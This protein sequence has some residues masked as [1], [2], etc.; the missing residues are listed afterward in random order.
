MHDVAHI[1]LHPLP[2]LLVLWP[3]VCAVLVRPLGRWREDVRDGFML[4]AT[5]VTLLG[6]AA[7]I[8]LIAEEHRIAADIPALLGM[9]H[10]VV[11]PF[12]ML[13]A[14]FTTFVWFAATLHS[15]DYLAHEQ[16]RDRFHVTSLVVL[17]A[18]LGVVLA[19]NL[20]TLYLFFEVLGLT[21]FLFVIHTQT[22]EAK[23]ASIKYLW[24]TVLGGF[25]LVAGIFLTYA[26]GHTGAI[27]PIPLEGTNE[28]LRWVTFGLLILGFGVKAGML[29][30][31]VWLP[32][33]HPVAPSPASALLSGVMIKA[34]AY[35][36]FR[37][38]TALFRP[39]VLEDISE[40][41]WHATSSFGLVVLWIGI[42]TMAIGVILALGQHN[43]KRML[44]YHSVSQM[45]FILAGIGAAGYLG[46]HGALG[47]AGGLLHVVNH[48]LFKGA[49]FLGI[50]A[51][52]FR[53]GELDMY[54]LGGLWR[55]MPWT[56]V[57]MLIAAAGI[58]GVPLFNGFVSKC[59]IHHALVEAYEVHHLLSLNIAEKIYVVTCGGTA[60]SFIKLIGLV[61]LGRAKQEY[62]PEVTDAP[63]RMLMALALLSAAMVT[64]GV[65]PHLLLRGVVSPGL[66]EW[67]LHADLIEY[68]LT[69]YF[70]SPADLMSVVVAFAIGATIFVVGMKLGLFHR[71]APAWFG[72]DYWYRRFASGFVTACRFI[73]EWY[74]RWIHALSHLLRSMRLGYRSLY[75]RTERN[76]HRTVV[77]ITTGAPG[78]RNQHFIQNAYIALERER[79]ASVRLAV[80]RTHEWLRSQPDPGETRVR[81]TI[82]AVRDIAG[83]MATRQLNQR[84]GVLADMV[85]TGEIEIARHSFDGVMREVRYFRNPVAHTALELAERRM[86][87]EDV[88]RDISAEVNRISSEER[89]ERRLRG[90]VAISHPVLPHVQHLGASARDITPS[91]AMLTEWR[92]RGLGRFERAAR[93]SVEI[94]RLIVE[95]TTQERSSWLTA[96]RLDPEG[97]LEARRQIQRY[98]RDMSLNMAMILVVLL[99][100]LLSIAAGINR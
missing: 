78:P 91:P 51:V 5:G 22:A 30:V 37:T 12:G 32:D 25:S 55:K 49:L 9:L 56:F 39:A 3:L 54:K 83:Y 28:I 52:A 73:G 10:F 50:G 26:L 71:H 82:D 16:H 62:G 46:S 57:F 67:A 97:V 81:D 69:K 75:A 61:F 77:T 95:V 38:V 96:E 8:P 65:R 6:A 63:P 94:I 76:W 45:G 66:H 84:M 1:T 58:T 33:A 60:C 79:Q 80:S 21:A 59:L 31:H 53:T 48:A 99:V 70:L 18:M 34:G 2:A 24:M 68:Y 4:F 44:A 86:A 47:I 43:A 23:R 11:D 27:G 90:A 40:E 13:F 92:V 98:A 72:V 20:V 14:L 19:G 93:W 36:I 15:L 35:G 41:L 87:G 88:L 17:S 89:F 42:A 64:I 29:P 7:L 100:F 85:R 74:E